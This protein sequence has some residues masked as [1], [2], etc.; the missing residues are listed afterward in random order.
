MGEQAEF[1][2]QMW[3][4]AL[5]HSPFHHTTD[6]DSSFVQY[7]ANIGQTLVLRVQ[8]AYYLTWLLLPQTVTK[9]PLLAGQMSKG[10]GFSRLACFA[11]YTPMVFDTKHSPQRPHIEMKVFQTTLNC[12][13]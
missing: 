2:L 1:P 4:P 7:K 5:T 10:I 3:T 12:H 8:P 13:P 9:A 11:T 6:N